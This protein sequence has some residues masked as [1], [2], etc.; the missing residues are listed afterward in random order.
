VNAPIEFAIHSIQWESDI[1]SFLV[2]SD[3]IVFHAEYDVE[4]RFARHH[5]NC[6]FVFEIFANR[7]AV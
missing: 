6:R 5:V 2:F 3:H 1:N 4:M 7:M